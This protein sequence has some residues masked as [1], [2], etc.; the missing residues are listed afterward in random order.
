M[1]TTSGR[2]PGR[3]YSIRKCV[4][5]R[6]DFGR[7]VASS[8][9]GGK[10]CDLVMKSLLAILGWIALSPVAY[11]QGYLPFRN[12]STTLISAGGVPM[13]GST[14]QQFI[15][16]VFLAPAT[17]VNAIGVQVA[18]SD[19][20]FQ[21][22]EAYNTNH[23]FGV[24]RLVSR[25]VPISYSPGTSVDF[26]VRG[27]SANAGATWQAALATWNNGSPLMPMF[28]GSSTI[29]NNLWIAGD[30]PMSPLFGLNPAAGEVLGFDMGFVPEPAV[31]TTLILAGVVFLRWRRR[32]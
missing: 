5:T 28:I 21:V 9:V 8:S 19:P 29:G 20:S 14:N 22:V 7:V 3:K 24:G 25:N 1:A 31:V 12:D 4:G 11:G 32:Q 26:V 17:T 13:P 2:L 30:L 18:F 23:S 10:N 16:A 6:V 15:F 27:W